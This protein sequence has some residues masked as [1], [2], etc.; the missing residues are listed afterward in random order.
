MTIY[1][2]GLAFSEGETG[3]WNDALCRSKVNANVY[4][5]DTYPDHWEIIEITN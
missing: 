1:T 5:P 3:W 4:T 2:V